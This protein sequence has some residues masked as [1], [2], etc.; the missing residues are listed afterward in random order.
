MTVTKRLAYVPLPNS[1]HVYVNGVEQ[2]FGV[3]YTLSANVVSIAS[4]AVFGDLVE[5]YYAHAGQVS[6]AK[7]TT[8]QLVSNSHG[9]QLRVVFVLPDGSRYEVPGVNSGGTGPEVEFGTFVLE[10]M[11]VEF[12]DLSYSVTWTE[13]NSAHIR[14]ALISGPGYVGYRYSF[15]DAPSDGDFDDVIIDVKSYEV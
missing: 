13:P 12:T 5:V 15:D 6:N 8:I 2:R 4:A 10:D 11:V 3:D 9:D 7:R 1:E 14:K